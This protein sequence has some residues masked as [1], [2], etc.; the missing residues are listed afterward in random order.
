MEKK[1]T[2]IL[3]EQKIDFAK[4]VSQEFTIM[5][6]GRV[7]REANIHSLTDEVIREYLTI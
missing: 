3:V 5:V 7:A 6:K 4:N 1:L 2:I